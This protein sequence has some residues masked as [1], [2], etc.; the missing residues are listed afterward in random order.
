MQ[1][2]KFCQKIMKQ[3]ISAPP[4]YSQASEGK[5]ELWL[6]AIGPL[7]CRAITFQVVK[8]FRFKDYSSFDKISVF[9]CTAAVQYMKWNTF[10]QHATR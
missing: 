5:K 4:E 1:F 8:P 6:D 3:L 10:R 7:V 2:R 9:K